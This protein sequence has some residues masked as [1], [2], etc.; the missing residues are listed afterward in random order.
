[1]ARLALPPRAGRACPGGVSGARHDVSVLLSLLA[2][3]RLA[4]PVS[5]SSTPWVGR[6]GEIRCDR[7]LCL[8]R[9]VG[10]GWR[11]EVEDRDEVEDGE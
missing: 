2:S 6:E 8:G 5:G 3:T 11:M 10:W 1:M 9:S 4:V 7:S